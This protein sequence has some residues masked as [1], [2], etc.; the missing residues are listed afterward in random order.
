MY[1][2]MRRKGY[3]GTDEDA[4][5]SMVSV[6]NFLNEGA[7][8][9]ICEWERRF[10]GGV[11]KALKGKEEGLGEGWPRLE[12]FQGRSKDLTPKARMLGMLGRVWPEKFGYVPFPPSRLLEG[13]S[14][15]NEL[16]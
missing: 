11:L 14:R 12:R 15:A 1:N 4:V 8:G 5:P 7:W 13:G 10:G 3:D 9:E 6:H 16:L 2:A